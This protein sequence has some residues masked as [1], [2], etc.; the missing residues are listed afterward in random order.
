M[1]TSSIMAVLFA[2]LFTLPTSGQDATRDDFKRFCAGHLGRWTGE[3]TSVINES[4]LGKKG[5][6]YTG[7]WEASLAEDG[8]AMT[9]RFIGP[10]SS[11]RGLAYFDAAAKK[12]RI[13]SVNSEGVINQH[14][15]HRE[16]DKWIRIT[17]Y[18]SA[19]GT[20]GKLESVITMPKDG[21]TI[22][23]VISGMV[24]DRIFKNQKNVWHR[25]SK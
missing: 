12:I 8:N 10:K 15:I 22:T 13:T 20:K 14:V 24:G 9:Q 17:H 16:G 21:K 2:T 25:V 11:N 18:T 6:T 19:N 5:D 3:V 7:Y 1:K 23:V 4:F